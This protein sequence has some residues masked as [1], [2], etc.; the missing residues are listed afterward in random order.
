[1]SILSPELSKRFSEWRTK[2]ANN[3]ITA[4]ELKEA[5]IALRSNRLSASA[6]ATKSAP[7]AKKVAKSVDSMLDELAG[8]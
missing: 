7:R 1:M 5:I 3:T 8:L 4:E 6:A 2:A